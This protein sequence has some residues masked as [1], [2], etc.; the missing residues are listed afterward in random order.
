MPIYICT[1]LKRI[2][3]SK[4]VRVDKIPSLLYVIQRTFRSLENN[5]AT[6]VRGIVFFMMFVL[7]KRYLY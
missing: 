1:M 6:L 5:L 4:N 3:F 7:I 2:F